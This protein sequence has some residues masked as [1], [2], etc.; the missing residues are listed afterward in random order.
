MINDATRSNAPGTYS[1]ILF[2]LDNTIL[3]F[4]RCERNAILKAVTFCDL[5]IENHTLSSFLEAYES[6]NAEYW[7][8]RAELSP[9]DMVEKSF[10]D[11]LD[12]LSLDAA[13][14]RRLCE[15]YRRIFS[16]EVFFE[17]EAL[18]TIRSLAST[19]RLG[20]IT[21]GVSPA[22]EMRVR[23]AR[24][25]HCFEEILVSDAVGCAKPDPRIFT[26]AL[27]RMHLGPHHVLY[28]GDSIRDDYHGATAA[29][30]D[31]CH[32]NRNGL[33]TKNDVTPA[34]SIHTV[35]RLREIVV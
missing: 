8:R 34:Y 2:D 31:F 24:I 16:T 23:A 29:G 3:D 7:R 14:A 1:A 32:Y 4:H 20:I 18:E 35:S 33:P 6:A 10:S 22:Q 11:A 21:N 13:P 5:P 27:K 26:I 30:I 12:A 28:V 19:H 17:P 15:I 25:E 9:R